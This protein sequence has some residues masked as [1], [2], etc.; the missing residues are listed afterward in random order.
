MDRV[1]CLA[2]VFQLD[3]ERNV[4]FGSPLCAGDYADTCAAQCSE[5]LAGDT[6]STFHVFAYDSDSGQILF[7][8]R[9]AHITLG[10]FECEFFVQYSNCQV[11]I[12]IPDG[13][14]RIVF[15]AGL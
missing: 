3:D 2:Q 13:K 9:V 14:C 5:Q 7:C 12:C 10:A 11:C 15:R 4:R 8:Y 6:R 1:Q